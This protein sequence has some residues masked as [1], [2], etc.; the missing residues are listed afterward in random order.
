MKIA[1]IGAGISGLT[2]GI[3]LKNAGHGVMIYEKSRG[4]GGRMATRYAEN[5]KTLKLDH[6]VPYVSAESDEFRFLLK[7]LY[8][9]NILEEW[10][11][12]I[13]KK[14]LKDAPLKHYSNLEKFYAP[15]G[16]NSIGKY[17]GKDLDIRFSEKVNRIDHAQKTDR[18]GHIWTL[19]CESGN[20]VKADAVIISAPAPQTI[21]LLKTA[22][23]KTEISGLIHDLEAVS[24]DPQFAMM[25]TY[26]HKN[27][28]DWGIIEV[29]DD[30][31]KF[32][33]N[34]SK[35]RDL[36][37]DA[38]V[39]HSTFEFASKNTEKDRDTITDVM[40]ERLTSLLGEWAALPDWK[41]LHF[42]R[43]SQTRDTLPHDFLEISGNGTPLALVGSYM[44]G[45][46]VET[47]YL[48]G[49]KLGK[50]WARQLPAKK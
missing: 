25:L 5:D 8:E 40:S 16:M 45:K 12:K 41:Q 38:L 21:A 34:E 32:I 18:K 47:A 27:L 50:H 46:T 7:E 31:I 13:I 6:G 39:V 28:S 37:K 23:K 30:I 4:Y 24:Y 43:Y 19:N 36:R 26:S 22:G 3:E 11:S 9:E 17:L 15:D 1:I 35:K 10:K 42:W 44:K 49:L 33:S 48:S 14:D 20:T 29:D 2:A